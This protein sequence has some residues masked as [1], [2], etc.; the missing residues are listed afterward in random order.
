MAKINKR[1]KK[2]RR[3]KVVIISLLVF[4][5]GIGGGFAYITTQFNELMREKIISL[6]EQSEVSHYY[7]LEFKKLRVN[8]L[9]MSVRIY[10]IRFSPLSEKHKPFF[11]ENGSLSLHVG[12]VI[13]K[14]ADLIDFLT[15]NEVTIERFELAHTAIKIENKKEKFA[16]FA[17]I[18]NAKPN[19]SLQLKISARHIYLDKTKLQFTGNEKKEVE[20]KFRDFSMEVD[21]LSL[22]K[23]PGDFRFSFSKLLATLSEAE[24]NSNG[25]AIISLDKLHFGIANLDVQ[26]LQGDFSFKYRDFFMELKAPSIITPDS[27]F[28]VSAASV[29]I[30]EQRKRLRIRDLEVHPNL[31]KPAFV[32]RFRY[33]TL[34]PDVK[35]G[36]V[37]FTNLRYRSLIDKQSLMADT[38]YISDVYAD[39]Y[40]TKRIPLNKNKFPNYLGKQVYGIKMPI[41]VS[42]VDIKNANVDFS[43]HQEDGRLSRIDINDISGVLLNLQNQNPDKKLLLNAKGRIHNVVPFS[44]EL[45]FDT[46]KDIF[47][48]KGRIFKSDL[49]KLN[50]VVSSFAPVKIKSGLL[51]SI[52]FNGFASRTDTRG[53]ML[54]LYEDLN[55]SI[56]KK[57]ENKKKDITNVLFSFAA[58]TYIYK[59]N[60]AKDHPPREV[61]FM[62][63]RNMN[64]GFI[65]VLVQG[66]LS[67]IKETIAPSKENRQKYKVVRKAAKAKNTEEQKTKNEE[68][69]PAKSK[70]FWKKKK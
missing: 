60:P 45:I 21:S 55:I 39:L 16:P 56:E 47:S 38:I 11:E 67:G 12:K 52:T 4:V 62:K 69:K 53:S 22:N 48:Y 28:T 59:N 19:D 46:Q 26:N 50:K 61:R 49:S 58:N 35:V 63:P 24:I 7:K 9:S 37:E 13:V 18:R 32:R 8:L 40:K 42:V 34:R 23:M 36:L 1:N 20:Y 29:L 25:G 51:K 15:N 70:K 31:N 5:L 10:D 3:R 6:Y 14:K 64:K 41:D 30:E 68:E 27:L 2:A 44:V 17:F 65:H 43:V 33:Q 54:F 66:L 57:D